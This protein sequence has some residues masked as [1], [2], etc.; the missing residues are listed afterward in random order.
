MCRWQSN[1]GHCLLAAAR[2]SLG[3]AYL[4]DYQVAEDV[5]VGR[6]VRVLEE[7]G[8]LERDVVA[9]YQNRR[10][11]SAKVK[12]FVDFMQDRFAQQRPW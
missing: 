8:G 3:L 10:H 2:D 7:W 12:L 1:S 4:P 11:L 6:L 9:V 5:K